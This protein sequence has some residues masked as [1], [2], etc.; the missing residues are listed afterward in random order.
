[1]LTK[2]SLL[3]AVSA[4]SLRT[5]PEEVKSAVANA[6]AA[7][8]KL[9]Q[10][11]TKLSST[12]AA[13]AAEDAT[14]MG[15]EDQ[16]EVSDEDAEADAAELS[17]AVN[18]KGK[19]LDFENDPEEVV[20]AY[21]DEEID[22]LMGYSDADPN[23]VEFADD[24]EE[25]KMTQAEWAELE[26]ADEDAEIENP[27]LVYGGLEEDSEAE[28][29]SA[30]EDADATE[31]EA[32][33]GEEADDGEGEME[34]EEVAPEED[35]DMLSLAKRAGK[36]KAVAF[37]SNTKLGL[38]RRR[39]VVVT[40]R[41]CNG[42]INARG[43][44]DKDDCTSTAVCPPG[45]TV[46]R[47]GMHGPG[48]GTYHGWMRLGR[49][50]RAICRARGSWVS[51]IHN[52]RV[53]AR[54]VCVSMRY[55]KHPRRVVSGRTGGN[56][57]AR[58]TCPRGYRA[59]GCMC[60]SWWMQ[61]RRPGNFGRRNARTCIQRMKGGRHWSTIETACAKVNRSRRTPRRRPRVV[62]RFNR[63]KPSRRSRKRAAR[64]AIR[65]NKRRGGRRTGGRNPLDEM[66]RTL[67][68]V[69]RSLR[70]M[71]RQLKSIQRQR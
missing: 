70:S 48:D 34:G 8:Q 25:A 38:P 42:G 13:T 27:F 51:R 30:A 61:C 10:D 18:F 69:D 6:D 68:R 1:M 50:R 43:R 4:I 63:N 45:Y 14:D 52:R 16:A 28:D 67:N 49:G 2:L 11:L 57:V 35:Q 44:G 23:G 17:T 33:D 15:A 36:D 37:L 65:R 39:H 47:C 53:R 66:E 3:A 55:R 62:R 40:S 5:S 59:M 29:M 21:T 64:R 32:E 24:A 41:S 26:D 54:A 9:D 56:R 71:E 12:E 20:K 31:A 60:H 46:K 58:V 19:V 22:A 7:M